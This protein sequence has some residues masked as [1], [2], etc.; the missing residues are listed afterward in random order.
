M[1]IG[2]NDEEVRGNQ[3]L[4]DQRLGL[5]WI[6]DNIEMFGGDKSKVCFI[7]NVLCKPRHNKDSFL[8]S[9]KRNFRAGHTKG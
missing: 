2:E 8:Y 1:A 7:H 4:D 3:G 9:D 5:Q 6:Q